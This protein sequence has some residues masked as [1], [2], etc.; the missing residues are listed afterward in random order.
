MRGVIAAAVIAAVLGGCACQSMWTDAPECPPPEGPP[1]GTMAAGYANPVFVP[2]ADPQCAWETVVGVVGAY[3]RIEHEEPIRLIGSEPIAGTITSLPEVSPT[4]FEP[5]RH[6]TVDPEQRI[7]NTLQSM[8]RRAVVQVIPVRSQGGC[9]VNVQVF[10]ELEDVVRPE[11]ATSGAA[12]LRYD[13][14]LTRVENPVTGGQITQ[15]WIARGRDAP[16][17]QY[18]IGDLLSRC[19][20]GGS[21]MVVRGQDK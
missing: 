17:E 15:G 11:H 10:K 4:I 14:S 18:I 9:M 20:Q 3:F 7:E 19:G 1:A 13:S 21:P 16:M 5:W 2:I 8:R 12:T 6:D